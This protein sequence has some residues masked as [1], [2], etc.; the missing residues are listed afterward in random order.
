[1]IS[2]SL[3]YLKRMEKHWMMNICLLN[4]NNQILQLTERG[5]DL[6][7]LGNAADH[8]KPLAALVALLPTLLTADV[9]AQRSSRPRIRVRLDHLQEMGQNHSQSVTGTGT[10]AATEDKR[11][12]ICFQFTYVV[13]NLYQN[14]LFKTGQASIK[15]TPL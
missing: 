14:F 11:L 6:L 9:N 10:M 2:L 4:I 7:V 8:Q 5:R 3:S 1:M 13:Q 15:F 12:I